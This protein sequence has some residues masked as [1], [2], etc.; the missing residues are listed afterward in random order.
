MTKKATEAAASTELQAAQNMSL[1]ELR[2]QLSTEMAE[3][4][5]KL[6]APSGNRIRLTDKK[7]TLPDGNVVEGT[8][9]VVVLEF[10]SK[11]N[12]YVGR[13][14][15]NNPRPPVCWAIGDDPRQLVPSDR[16][17]NPQSVDCASCPKNQFGPNNEAKECKN[18]RV[19]AVLPIDADPAQTDIMTIEVS[20]TGIGS[21]D[22]FVRRVVDS[23]GV[24]PI[25]AIVEIGFHPDRDYESLVF[26]N[27]I[28]NEGIA[29]YM[30]LREEAKR[31]VFI[32]PELPDESVAS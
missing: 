10:T 26:G 15:R 31:T 32:E 27:F 7:F 5:N 20:P 4:Q 12:L 8:I 29:A 22:K 16:V 6:G 21:F 30:P 18:C 3:I 9:R 24:P 11:N 28:P 1:A 17:P 13:F 2:E 14:N 19:L 23:L 25:G